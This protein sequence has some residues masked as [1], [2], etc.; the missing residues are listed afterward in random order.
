MNTLVSSVLCST[1]KRIEEGSVYRLSRPGVVDFSLGSRSPN[2]YFV[3]KTRLK[4]LFD[5]TRLL[6]VRRSVLPIDLTVHCRAEDGVASGFSIWLT[7]P[8][9]RFL[10]GIEAV[11]HSWWTVSGSSF[12][13][14]NP[15]CYAFNSD[16][17]GTCPNELLPIDRH[18][19]L[20]IFWF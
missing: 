13:T 15:R 20:N 7:W 12:W 11:S 16:H 8:L 1:S 10:F 4:P 3:I 14:S 9:W 6:V 18:R 19:R 17:L 5:H 2:F